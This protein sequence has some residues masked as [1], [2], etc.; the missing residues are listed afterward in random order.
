MPQLVLGDYHRLLAGPAQV[1]GRDGG[2]RNSL[3]SDYLR[4]GFR[5]CGSGPQCRS[6]PQCLWC[7]VYRSLSRRL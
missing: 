1:S 6:G 3:R 5:R 7:T 2:K 4:T